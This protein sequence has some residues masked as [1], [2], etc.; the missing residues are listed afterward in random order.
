MINKKNNSGKTLADGEVLLSHGM[1]T[2]ALKCKFIYYAIIQS[3][4]H[5]TQLLLP[6]SETGLKNG[7]RKHHKSNGE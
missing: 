3:F 1:Q 7:R 2:L 6:F 4:I 5:W